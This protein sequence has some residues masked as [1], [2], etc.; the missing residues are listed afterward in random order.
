[1]MR[2]GGTAG[3]SRPAH[4]R[5]DMPPRRI[6]K[7]ARD[8][9]VY[10]ALL[11]AMVFSG[12]QDPSA[13]VYGTAPPRLRAVDV[14][15]EIGAMRVSAILSVA[16]MAA[17]VVSAAASMPAAAE[18]GIK[19]ALDWRFEGPAAPFL[20]AI[21]K[22][23]F[24]AEGLDVSIEPGNGSVEPINRV[25]TGGYDFG[26][27]DINTLIR[28][29]DQTPANAVKA[30]FMVHNKPPF[31]IISRKSRGIT[32][33]KDLEGKKLGA[34]AGDAAF[35]QWPVFVQA[36]GIDA[37][38]VKVENVGF[39]VREPML[40]AAQVDAITGFS[41]SAYV[42]LKDRGVPVDDLVLMPMANYGV[43]LYGN[44]IIVN[45]KFAAEKP[46]AV[47]GFLRAMLKGLTDSVRDP[48]RA[49]E[50][51]LRRNDLAKRE[52]ELERLRMAIRDNIV[53]AEVRANGYGAVDFARLQAAI[54]QIGQSYKFK[55]KH[56]AADMFDDSFLP[57]EAD[58]RLR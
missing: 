23:Y 3:R 38:K 58:R 37:T 29:R 39:P 36:N 34:P 12:E 27:G 47:R 40:A 2:D 43:N 46:E 18:T 26:F 6:N 17:F 57:P 14:A 28:F 31:A 35:A 25:A 1:M 4:A 21:D 42:T 13:N 52:T 19:F 8:S 48:G 55:A 44:A 51:V 16:R 33:P 50:S 10:L 24:T 53:T 15:R 9:A 5:C 45:A 41:F 49:I 30:V 56:N 54:D 7:K 32:A 22:G 11:D 20:V